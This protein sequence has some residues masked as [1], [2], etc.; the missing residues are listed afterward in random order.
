MNQLIVF[1][2]C[3][4]MGVVAWLLFV[5]TLAAVILYRKLRQR[6]WL[7]P[8]LMCTAL[9]WLAA[10]VYT[11]LLSRRAAAPQEPCF[12]PF[13]ALWQ[14]LNGGSSELLLTSFMNIALF[15]PGG[16]LVRALRPTGKHAGGLPLTMLLFVCFSFGIEYFQY[17][18]ALGSPEADDVLHNTLGALLGWL[19]FHVFLPDPAVT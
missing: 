3:L 7:R 10:V 5:G 1:I 18:F 17:A 14:V 12:I 8:V 13:Y 2:Y 4:P 19:C 15:Y 11:T 6:R 9:L 16:V